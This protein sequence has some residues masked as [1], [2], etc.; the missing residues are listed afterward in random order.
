MYDSPLD[1]GKKPIKN[2]RNQLNIPNGNLFKKGIPEKNDDPE[3]NL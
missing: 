3:Y 2:N 1:Q